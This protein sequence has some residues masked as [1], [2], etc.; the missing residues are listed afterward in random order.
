MVKAATQLKVVE[1][2]IQG[3]KCSWK[4]KADILGMKEPQKHKNLSINSAQLNYT[5]MGGKPQV[6]P[7]VDYRRIESYMALRS[8]SLM[9][10]KMNVFPNHTAQAAES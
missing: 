2:I 9:L 10:F 7:T 4:F 5:R 8:M 3:W 1:K 6:A